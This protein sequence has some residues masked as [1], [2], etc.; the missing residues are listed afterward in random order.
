MS[1]IV[2]F[3]VVLGVSAAIAITLGLYVADKPIPE[4]IKPW[5]PWVSF[6]VVPMMYVGIRR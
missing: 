5:I 2:S 1:K 6:F 4:Q 3:L